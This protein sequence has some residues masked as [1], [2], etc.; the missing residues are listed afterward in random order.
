MY[1]QENLQK[2]A[3]MPFYFT[4]LLA[5]VVQCLKRG[6]LLCL[7]F[8]TSFI[9]TMKIYILELLAGIEGWQLGWIRSPDLPDESGV[10]MN[11]TQPPG[12]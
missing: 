4:T 3:S 1:Q 8:L 10:W 7:F 2:L 6:C 9:I 11:V 5:L 12:V